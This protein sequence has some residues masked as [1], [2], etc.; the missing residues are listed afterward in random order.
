[1]YFI[2]L[3]KKIMSERQ[4]LINRY[5]SDL[6]IHMKT[7]YRLNFLRYESEPN[8][9]HMLEQ[10]LNDAE[11]QCPNA[12]I[13]KAMDAILKDR[14]AVVQIGG[15]HHVKVDKDKESKLFSTM[16]NSQ[17]KAMSY[18]HQMLYANALEEYEKCLKKNQQEKFFKERC[19]C[20]LV[21]GQYSM[22]YDMAIQSKDPERIFL[23]SILV[24]DLERSKSCIPILKSY[25]KEGNHSLVTIYELIH[26]ILY[27]S[28][29]FHPIE[30]TISLYHSIIQSHSQQEYPIFLEI[31]DYIS[32]RQYS[33]AIAMLPTIQQMLNESIFTNNNSELITQSISDNI[34]SIL[35]KPYSRVRLDFLIASTDLSL[36]DLVASMRRSIRS[37][38]IVGHLN[39]TEGLFDQKEITEHKQQRDITD[40]IQI[41]IE[42]FELAMWKKNQPTLIN[43]WD[44]K[45]QRKPSS[46]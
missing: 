40:Q 42:K 29:A 10:G 41:V 9:L 33:R 39:L 26:I 14:K 21:L 23:T 35:V 1:M 6:P 4:R 46:K 7:L 3:K 16:E 20:Y 44:T 15:Y 8:A 13:K 36:N 19:E 17:Q 43:H 30:E 18:M 32:N 45:P 5:I 11:T 25:I 37:G 31:F 34:V 2:F 22:A 28:L 38:K 27:V 24:G 12:G